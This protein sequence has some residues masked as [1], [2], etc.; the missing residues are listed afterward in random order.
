MRCQQAYDSAKP[1]APIHETS[2]SFNDLNTIDRKL[3]DLQSVLITPLLTF[4]SNAVVK[5]DDAVESK[6]ADHWLG[7]PS[8]CSD[9]SYSRMVCNLVDNVG[10]CSLAQGFRADGRHRYRTSLQL[11]AVT[12]ACH[13]SLVE[14]R[15]CR[16]EH[17]VVLG[18]PVHPNTRDAR[19]V[20][21]VFH[22][23]EKCPRRK[24]V[25]QV[26]SLH[27][28]SRPATQICNDCSR[29]YQR[30]TVACV[31]NLAEDG[32]LTKDSC[33]DEKVDCQ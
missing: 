33:R 18:P 17:Y 2:C 19:L 7:Y 27:V 30:G 31:C 16:C 4:L 28:R 29:P 20:T 13:D 25:N 10:S 5:N 3:I 23:D 1:I 14:L 21:R 32:M 9:L 26:H 22:F 6:T 8:S 11:R 24:I 12:D 15:N